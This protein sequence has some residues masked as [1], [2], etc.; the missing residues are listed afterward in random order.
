[1]LSVRILRLFVATAF[2]AVGFSCFSLMGCGSETS[3]TDSSST[4]LAPKGIWTTD[5]KAALAQAKKEGKDVLINFT[6]SDWCGYCIELQNKVFR[7]KDFSDGA[8]KDFV[9]LEVD[10]PNDQS[11]I[12]PEIQ[13]Q[14]NE[15][16][17]K[18]SIEGF[19]AI[20][21]VD[22][23]GR[24]YART[25]YQPVGPQK[26]VEHL[27]E[28][29]DVRKKRDADFAA[30]GKLSGIKKALKLN[31]ALNDIPP[32]WM[33]TSYADVVEEIVSLDADNK[34]GLRQEYA[35][36]L[37]VSQLQ[38]KLKEIQTLLQTTGDIDAALKKVDEIETDFADFEPARSV[39]VQFRLQLLQMDGRN[40]DIV[41][42]ANSLLADKAIKGDARLP[43]LGAK[44]NA[45]AQAEKF[46]AALDVAETMHQEFNKDK[47]L[48]TRILIARAEL[49]SKLKRNDEAR[50]ALQEARDLGGPESKAII[51]SAEKS[52]FSTKK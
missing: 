1:M 9:L 40:D 50:T 34:A 18:F 6:G 46:E 47:Q 31:E 41:K 51:D 7:F 52:I 15:L 22:E 23:Q 32:E 3:A 5:Y 24:P 37:L 14:N 35:E 44:L 21:L 10:F 17:Q 27:S 29:T 13:A 11:L 16:Q 43:I 33:F 38:M 25:G 36:Q 4:E 26:Y 19:P 48:A 8:T 2:V 12:T 49:L 30:A 45:L 28:F 39:A 42:L 20:L